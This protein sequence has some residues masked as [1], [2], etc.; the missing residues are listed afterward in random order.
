[1]DF[2]KLLTNK[3]VFLFDGAIGTELA[4]RGL[5]TYI[6]VNLTK[7]EHILDI[8]R[9]YAAVGVDALTTNTFT[10]NRV[11]I[12]SHGLDADLREVNLAG[13][14][15]AR[16]AA[17]KGQYVFGDLGPTGC[18][19]EPY[20]EYTE[21]H[22]HQNFL[23]QAAIL[24]TGGVDGFIIETMTDLREAVCALKACKEAAGLPVIVTLSFSTIKNGGRTIMGS[25]V[26]ESATAL[27]KYGADAVGANCGE[28]T[29]KELA[30]I[31]AMY[32]RQT[33]LPIIIQPN[34]GKP[35]LLGGRTVYDMPPEEFAEGVMQ[36]VD[37]SATILGGCCGTTPAHLQ[38]L[39]RL[40]R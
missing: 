3:K 39:V 23:E 9:E 33:A 20:G 18:L 24:A 2:K 28:L 37:S 1:M 32:K 14:R 19:L 16:E 13:A 40:L 35:K 38:A 8:H 31:A 6:T 30:R 10:M 11:Y 27:E 29:P 4:R 12:E 26:A 34:A 25:A 22:F 21:E 5:E 15:L 17:G 7:P 36:C